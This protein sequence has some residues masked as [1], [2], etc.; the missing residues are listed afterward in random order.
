MDHTQRFEQTFHLKRAVV[1]ALRPIPMDAPFYDA[2]M[3]PFAAIK[4]QYWMELFDE[5][6]T[7]GQAP[8]TEFMLRNVLPLV[9]TGR[10]ETYKDIYHRVYWEN[11]NNGFSSGVYPD[12]GK[13]DYMLCDILAKRNGQPLHRFL[14]AGRDWVNVYASGHGVNTAIDALVKEAQDF[15][16]LGYSVYKMKV[17]SN[18]GSDNKGDAE[19]V[20]IMRDVIGPNARLAID[21]NQV[22]NAKEAMAFF[23][24]VEKYS[25]AWYEEPV[26]SHDLEELEKITK[27]CP[28][29]VS[30]G[31]SM[32]NHYFFKAYVDA[33]VR[34]L[35]HNM[36]NP[37]FEDW[38][39]V[40]DLA[41]AKGLM[42]SSG[43]L[44]MV[45]AYL[46][47]A[48]EDCWQ[49][50][51]KPTNGPVMRYMKIKPEEREGKFYIPNEPGSP[52]TPDWEKLDK[53]GY[54]DGRKYYYPP[55][56]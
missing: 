29:P 23:D 8:V 18:F 25:I 10:R 39:Q 28:V 2:T 45:C 31:E 50:Y 35:Q 41:K 37:G 34:H 54:L 32:R 5:D 26:H 47:T 3:G 53:D 14:G 30:M 11:R 15:K 46:A 40:R 4:V 13:L 44:P 38:R 6:G 33:G 24:L 48:D 21:A 27:L 22:W 17:A 1:H 51:L 20:R 16:A 12:V 9:L 43:G 19:R 56:E 7:S 49:E 42:F 52:M 36:Q 55:G